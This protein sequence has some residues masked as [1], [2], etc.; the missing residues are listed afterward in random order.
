MRNK[1]KTSKKYLIIST[2][3][4]EGPYILEWLAY[5]RAIG[6]T[7]F[8]IYTNDCSDGTD[9][10]LDRLQH[11]GIV[12]H[13]RNKVLKRGPHKSAL[14]YAQAHEAYKS[15]DWVYVCDV[16]EFLNIKIGNGHIEDLIER[17][18]DADA[19]PIA[20][21]LFS[22]NSHLAQ[23]PGMCT[24]VFTDAQPQTAK[25]GDKGRFV[26]SLFKPS[27]HIER[28]GLHA[29]VYKK[30]HADRVNWGSIWQENDPESPPDRPLNYFGYEVVQINH[31][32][33]RSIDAFLLKRDRGR[34]NH[35][36]ETLGSDYWR[37]WCIGGE[38][39]TSIQNHASA[40]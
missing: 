40:M 31:Y 24:D 11:N 8:L 2:M 25:E 3:K 27:S 19:I 1:K 29:P 6:F 12:T 23:F 9:L 36:G 16:D 21:R 34:A 38:D 14:K 20:W 33:V 30:P 15:T 39:D 4:D 32:A 35:V 18:P 13:V 10:L 26:K 7:D 37:R 17:F 22:N 28:F 5:H